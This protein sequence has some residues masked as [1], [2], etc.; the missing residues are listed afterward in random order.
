MKV[1]NEVDVLSEG[2]STD[3]KS[4]D[5]VYTPLL[6]FSIKKAE[7][8]VGDGFFVLVVCVSLHM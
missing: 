6:T 1:E 3:M 5:E 8:E 2:G 4:N 7:P